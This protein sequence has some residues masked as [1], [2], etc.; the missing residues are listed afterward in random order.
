MT[1]VVIFTARR[2]NNL[3]FCDTFLLD[4]DIL[5]HVPMSL[6]ILLQGRSGL[7]TV[8]EQHGIM[9]KTTNQTMWEEPWKCHSYVGNGKVKEGRKFLQLSISVS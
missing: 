6:D 9:N 7:W 4:S 8:C 3:Q 2:A 1:R 5:I